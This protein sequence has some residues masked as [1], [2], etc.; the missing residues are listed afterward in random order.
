MSY[1]N[2]KILENKVAHKNIVITMLF[3]LLT[4]SVFA[5]L[6]FTLYLLD[7]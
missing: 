2:Q 7:Y 4:F 5:N 6:L 1:R 3:C